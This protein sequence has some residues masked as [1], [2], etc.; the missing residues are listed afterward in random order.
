MLLPPPPPLSHALEV[1]Y[2]KLYGHGILAWAS[3]IQRQIGFQSRGKYRYGPTQVG[4]QV[5]GGSVLT[6]AANRRA[7]APPRVLQTWLR[8]MISVSDNYNIQWGKE[9]Q[10]GTQ[11]PDG[12]RGRTA[13][14]EGREKPRGN[15][16]RGLGCPA[17]RSPAVVTYAGPG[18]VRPGRGR[19][20]TT[21]SL[22]PRSG[23][24]AP[25]GPAQLH[26][27]WSP[28]T[29][30]S[31]EGKRLI[32]LPA[33]RYPLGRPSPWHLRLPAG[34]GA[35]SGGRDQ[36]GQ[37][38]RPLPLP[39]PRLVLGNATSRTW[40]T[41]PVGPRGQANGGRR[42]MRSAAP[43]R[44]F[45]F[46]GGSG[47]AGGGGG[48][49]GARSG[50]WHQLRRRRPARARP[51]P[52]R[53]R[54]RRGGKL[55]GRRS[56][57]PHRASYL[58][59]AEPLAS[60]GSQQPALLS[61]AGVPRPPAGRRERERRRR[62]VAKAPARRRG[63]PNPVKCVDFSPESFPVVSSAP[64][65]HRGLA[66]PWGFGGRG[67]R[68]VES[69]LPFLGGAGWEEKSCVSVQSEGSTAPTARGAPAV[70]R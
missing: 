53:R 34:P 46:T 37:A 11:G 1:K 57:P 9:N 23:A 42:S 22:P 3:S 26:S 29:G 54:S 61:R 14:L 67:F 68:G 8:S 47:G 4:L 21:R 38:T 66:L 27:P 10:C 51:G 32:Q 44:R 65:C 43:A 20:W 70:P 33:L 59:K 19:L 58:P 12:V 35:R 2:L 52:G 55:R 7:E 56:S 25:A 16:A 15:A 18:P 41:T 28:D 31:L 40:T 24:A 5:V 69:D 49:A 17:P 13:G 36:E 64:G 39:L 48:P 50:L 62:P 63:S 30:G 60:L 45:E 6:Q